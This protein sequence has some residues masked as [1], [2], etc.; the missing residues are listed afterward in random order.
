LRCGLDNLD[1]AFTT[2]SLCTGTC[3]RI[4]THRL[5]QLDALFTARPAAPDGRACR[6]WTARSVRA[7]RRL[8]RA[9]TTRQALGPEIPVARD[10]DRLRTRL[11]AFADAGCPI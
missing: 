5:A 11:R 6:R 2:G 4:I 9:I 10:I 8:D 3:A 7:V 1:R